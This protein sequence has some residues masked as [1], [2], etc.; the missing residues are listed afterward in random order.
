LILKKLFK[1]K[2]SRRSFIEK[3]IVSLSLGIGTSYAMS[4]KNRAKPFSKP[5]SSKD[6]NWSKIQS[7]FILEDNAAY[8]NNASLGLPP[9]DVVSSV[10]RGYDELSKNPLKGKR[11]LQN[12]I[13]SKVIPGLSGFFGTKKNELILTR[14]A[15]EALFLQTHGF[16]LNPGDNVVVSSQEHPAALQPWKHRNINENIKLNQVYIPSPLISDEDTINRLFAAVTPKTK[17]ISFC[18]V[19]R[20]GHKYP[21]KKIAHIARKKGIATLVDGAQAVGQFPIDINDLGC[22]AYSAS[23]HKWILAPSGTGFLFINKNSLKYFKS[24]FGGDSL[25]VEGQFNPPG[26]KDLPVRAAIYDALRF[27]DSI[28]IKN[29]EKRCRYLSDYLK[30]SLKEI[31]RVKLLSGNSKQSAPGSTIFEM[32]GIDAIEAVQVFEDRIQFYIDEHQRDGHNAIRI[33]THFY[34]SRSEIDQLINHLKK[35]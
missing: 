2:V 33:S 11:T 3:G 22:D 18:H 13:S 35:L 25:T 23:L 1:T 17:A 15:S 28:G 21:V 14:N 9:I 4:Q 7:R 24:P 19:T 29:I 16:I 10:K 27:I 5:N 20:G 34:N 32:D 26:T 30:S 6:E 12:I 31:G 8:F